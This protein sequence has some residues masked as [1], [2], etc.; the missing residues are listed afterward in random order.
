MAF[1]EHAPRSPEAPPVTVVAPTRI[2]PDVSVPSSLS[3]DATAAIVDAAPAV[4][5]PAAIDATV[6]VET[7][8]SAAVE[9]DAGARAHGRSRHGHASRAERDSQAAQ[10]AHTTQPTAPAPDAGS[11]RPRLL[12]PGGSYPQ[13]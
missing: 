9:I 1:T 8:A 10:P 6:A 13:K 3:H 4:A 7:D 11:H 2:R 5:E 12:A